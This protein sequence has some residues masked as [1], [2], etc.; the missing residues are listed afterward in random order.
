VNE[1][2]YKTSFNLTREE[3]E[4]LLTINKNLNEAERIL[5]KRAQIPANNHEW[6]RQVLMNI[7]IGFISLALF[8][9][10]ASIVSWLFLII[11][12]LIFGYEVFDIISIYKTKRIQEEVKFPEIHT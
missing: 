4:Y 12:F 8:Y 3:R 9:I 6:I 2:T 10:W 1:E 5:I 7:S 11:A